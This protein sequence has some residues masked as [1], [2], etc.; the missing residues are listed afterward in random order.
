MTSISILRAATTVA[1]N[2]NETLAGCVLRNETTG[3]REWIEGA[4]L[5][6]ARRIISRRTGVWTAR[7]YGIVDGKAFIYA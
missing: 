1:G 4:G 7:G 2:G 5:A 6:S 3:E